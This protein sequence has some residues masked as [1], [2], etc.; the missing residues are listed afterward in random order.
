MK[1]PPLV[2]PSRVG[3]GK[4]DK[5]TPNGQFEAYEKECMHY[6]KLFF[7]RPARRSVRVLQ[8][9]ASFLASNFAMAFSLVGL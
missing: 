5:F 2:L 4:W 7:N 6:T 1:G 8:K 3:V 9:R